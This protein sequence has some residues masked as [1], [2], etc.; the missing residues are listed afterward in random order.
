[1]LNAMLDKTTLLPTTSKTYPS[2]VNVGLD[3]TLRLDIENM[4]ERQL[5]SSGRKG[6]TPKTVQDNFVLLRPLLPLCLAIPIDSLHYT[7]IFRCK[8]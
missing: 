4:N 3:C 1:M 5:W 8:A 7:T 2:A 6:Q